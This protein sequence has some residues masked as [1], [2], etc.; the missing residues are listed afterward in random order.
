MKKFEFC[1]WC[2]AKIEIPKAINPKKLLV[3]SK[4]CRDAEILFR[5]LF[6][7][8]AINRRAHYEVLTRGTDNGQ[9]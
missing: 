2:E 6:S 7:D 3:C 1:S 5:K 8:G 9:G 4:G